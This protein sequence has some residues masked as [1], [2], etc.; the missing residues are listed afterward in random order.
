MQCPNGKAIV[1]ITSD[2]GS[3]VYCATPVDGLLATDACEARWFD[4]S[5]NT[6]IN[7]DNYTPEDFA[8]GSYKVNVRDDEYIA[9]LAYWGSYHKAGAVLVCKAHGGGSFGPYQQSVTDSTGWTAFCSSNAYLPVGTNSKGWVNSLCKTHNYA[10]DTAQTTKRTD[11]TGVGA[12]GIA[13]WATGTTK[14][15]CP[16][17]M[18]ANAFTKDGSTLSCVKANVSI[19]YSC[20]TIWFDKGNHNFVMRDGVGDWAPGAYKG[21]IDSGYNYIAGVASGNG[22]IKGILECK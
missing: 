9:G 1:G 16:A 5:N 6:T 20:Q 7:F 10:L 22:I 12:H 15:E 11:E 18:V 3:A 8:V 2:L 14:R 19:P 13:D 21:E 4:Q 17:G